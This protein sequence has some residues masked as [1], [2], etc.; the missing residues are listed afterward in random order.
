MSRNG[1]GSNGGNGHGAEALPSAATH[2]M[3]D[4]RAA[5]DRQAAFFKSLVDMSEAAGAEYVKELQ[6]LRHGVTERLHQQDADIA[7]LKARLDAV[8]ARQAEAERPE[9]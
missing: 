2:F 1:N 8:E 3:D 9:P 5:F 4:V 7:A 6:K